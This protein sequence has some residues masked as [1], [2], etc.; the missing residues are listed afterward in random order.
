MLKFWCFIKESKNMTVFSF[1]LVFILSVISWIFQKKYGK[2][3]KLP[4]GPP[5]LPIIGSI[6]FLN[7]KKGNADATLHKSFYKLYPDIYT[8]WLGSKPLLVIQNFN[9]A[10]DLF[11]REE[12]CGRGTPSKFHLNY[13]RGKNGQP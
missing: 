10:K 3:N 12:F 7:R 5:A 4:P 1:V 11:I 9:L 6:P 2:Y 13:I 8:L